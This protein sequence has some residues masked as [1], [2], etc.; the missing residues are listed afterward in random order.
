MSQSAMPI[1]N[2]SQSNPDG[3]GLRDVPAL[4]RRVADTIEA[5]GDV[6]VEDL[7]FHTSVTPGMNDIVITVYFY[8]KG[9]KD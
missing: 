7:V 6:E 3:P 9:A 4:L 8:S 5:Y 2:F 1:R